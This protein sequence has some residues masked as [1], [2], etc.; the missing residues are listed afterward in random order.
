MKETR[1]K[2]QKPY[3]FWNWGTGIAITIVVAASLMLFL[4][5]KS[6][7]V[8]YDMA[9]KDYYAEELKFNGKMKASENA[10]H[11]SSPLTINETDDFLVI[12]FPA[13]CIG[14]KLEGTLL[15]YRP[16]GENNDINLP[17]TPDEDGKIMITKQH[18]LK[19]LYELK[20]NWTMNGKSYN[21]EKNFFVQ[22]I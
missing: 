16:S 14:Q 20:A 12:Q 5:F 11:L 4:V 18:L 2:P 10:L 1:T 21:V 17:L 9:E 7:R 8:T 13:E 22:L 19:G 3:G 6:T 15:L